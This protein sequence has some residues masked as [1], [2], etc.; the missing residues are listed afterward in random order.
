MKFFRRFRKNISLRIV[1]I[2]GLSIMFA[3][4]LL[5]AGH[6]KRELSYDRH[7]ANAERIAR[8]TLQFDDQP[9]DGR[10]WGNAINA[11]LQQLPEI[12]RTA[13][14]SQVNTG[15]L[16]CQGK[17]RIINDFYL[18]NRDFLHVFDIPLLQGVRDDALQRKNQVLISERF[19]RQLFGDVG[20]DG[21]QLPEIYID[22]NRFSDTVFVSG[23]FKDI[24]E[25]SHFHTDIL[26]H[27]GDDDELFTYVYLLLKHHT[28]TKAL[29]QKIT[30]LI[31]DSELFKP[32]QTRARLMPLTDIHL[33]SRN[34]REMS[35]NGSIYY[36]YLIVG[37]N[38]LLLT[39]VL[40]NL[41]LNASL[42]FSYNRRYYQIVRLHGG[43][44]SAV[45]KDEAM[46]AL[47]L[48]IISIMAGGL[49]AFWASTSGFLSG[50][51][52][53]VE[54][55]VLCILFLVFIVAVS[56]LP[57]VTAISSTLFLNTNHDWKPVRF[58]YSNVKWMLTVQ[59]AVVMIVVILAFGINKQMNLVK[60]TQVGGNERNI[61]VM[62]D[63]PFQVKAR[64]S[65]LK[66]E[67]LKYTEIESVTASFQLPGNAIRDAIGVRKEDD[68]EW[69]TIPLMVSGED[70]LPFFQVDMIAGRSFS[71]GRYDYQA[72]E[73]MF[74]EYVSQRN[75]SEDIEEYVINRKALAV[76][77]YNTPEEA[78]GEMLRIGHGSLDYIRRGVIVG[79]TEDFNYTGLYEE[80]IPLFIMQRNVFLHCIMVRLAPGRVLQARAVFER[81]WSEVIPEFPADYTFMNDVFDRMYRNEM[82]AQRLVYL[83]SLLCLVI[84]DLG[85]IIFM[86]FIIRRRT[87]EIGIRKVLGASVGEIIRMLN[88]DFIRYIALAFAI[89]VPVAWYVMHRW[90]ERFAYRTSLDWWIFVL[91]GLGVLFISMI[92]VSLQSWRAAN[93][94]L[95]E[96]IENF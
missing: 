87:K 34:L 64:Y 12:D 61:L 81:V 85:L 46:S 22:S 63:Q 77:G 7:H 6:I 88:L 60:D 74:R 14:L 11:A 16:T 56:L 79:V 94:N 95:V 13:K 73:A 86:A 32:S 54:T 67:L 65:L 15:V 5:S 75:Y 72:E 80:T 92:S 48:G 21:F 55:S 17:H 43:P 20:H 29:A 89:A 82:N 19:A 27:L 45:F 57:A 83:F 91:A 31:T 30:N 35:V 10:V 62:S 52:P 66:T 18:V 58:S 93:Q 78:V 40:F 49:A 47:F 3:C 50:Q 71:P 36:I 26:L 41:W 23:I 70:F 90:L 25:T 42:I 53:F 24:P 1:N 38:L 76:L 33:H 28:D 4:M 8:L 44:S 96:A 68:M 9:V 39:V 2:A 84:A 37:A 59:Y 69:R 51:I